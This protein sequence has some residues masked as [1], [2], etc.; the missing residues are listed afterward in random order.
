MTR[1]I[2]ERFN[3]LSKV[4]QLADYTRILSVQ[5]SVSEDTKTSLDLI[6]KVNYASILLP[7]LSKT[8]QLLFFD[9]KSDP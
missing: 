6:E 1:N 2:P 3:N 8:E 4:A 7:L 9:V 5:P